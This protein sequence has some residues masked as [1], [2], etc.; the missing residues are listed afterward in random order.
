MALRTTASARD[1]LAGRITS[2]YCYRRKAP[3]RAPRYP[4]RHLGRPHGSSEVGRDRV[5]VAAGGTEAAGHEATGPVKA[6]KR[7]QRWDRGRGAQ[8]GHVRG[9]DGEA[10]ALQRGHAAEGAL[11]EGQDT[12]CPIAVRQHHEGGIGWA[13]PQ[14]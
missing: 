12:T 6:G 10:A 13:K 14:V 11:V 9:Q 1:V 4:S 7:E 8:S 2:L 5:A 3:V